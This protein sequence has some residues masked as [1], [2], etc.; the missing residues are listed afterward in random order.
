MKHAHHHARNTHP[1]R[2]HYTP[3]CTQCTKHTTHTITLSMTVEGSL[4]HVF[5]VYELFAVSLRPFLAQAAAAAAAIRRICVDAHGL[6]CCCITGYVQFACKSGGDCD[7]SVQPRVDPQSMHGSKPRSGSQP[8]HGSQPGHR[9]DRGA[10]S[11]I[12]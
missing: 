6:I 9:S 4:A 8:R 10:S 7:V 11:V 5:Y 1:P 2:T 12:V 3:P